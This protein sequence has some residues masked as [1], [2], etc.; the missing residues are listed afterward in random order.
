MCCDVPPYERLPRKRKGKRT[1]LPLTPLRYDMEREVLFLL[2]GNEAERHFFQTDQSD[3]CFWYSRL[4]MTL[5]EE[6]GEA[7]GEED[8]AIAVKCMELFTPG[9][10]EMFTAM[11]EIEERCRRMLS[12]QP[13]CLWPAVVKVVDIM[14]E[15]GLPDHEQVEEA[16]RSIGV[17][18]L[19]S[20]SAEELL[21]Q[22]VRI[23]W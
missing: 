12:D 9:W 6:V 2:A 14:K 21:R 22:G 18:P 17:T 23:P 5:W 16:M 19:P 4:G 7:D 11:C 10:S 1:K 13:G 15:E 20:W 3:P 8:I